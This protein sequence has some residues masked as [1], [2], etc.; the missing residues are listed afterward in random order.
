MSRWSTK[1]CTKSNFDD[2]FNILTYF[3]EVTKTIEIDLS[4]DS[5]PDQ[6]MK[7]LTDFL[8]KNRNIENLS[9]NLNGNQLTD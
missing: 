9:L 3:K 1:A 4:D 6:Y 2:F 7:N 8:I 5:L